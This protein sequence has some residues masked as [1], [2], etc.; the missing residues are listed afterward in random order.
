MKKKIE[1]DTGYAVFIPNYAEK[2]SVRYPIEPY[3]V[4]LITNKKE[5]VKAAAYLM[6]QW[7]ITFQDFV[8]SYNKEKKK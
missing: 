2:K 3:M 6:S 8:D 4:E 1:K 5:A 7:D